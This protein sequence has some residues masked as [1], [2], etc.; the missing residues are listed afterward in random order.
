[1]SSLPPYEQETSLKKK[2]PSKKEK[3]MSSSSTTLAAKNKKESVVAS[4]EAS[5]GP[6]DSS[7]SGISKA[8]SSLN[9]NK[10]ATVAAAAAATAS[11]ASTASSNAASMA[12]A[13]EK[14]KWS[15]VISD[16]DLGDLDEEE[17]LELEMTSSSR[18]SSIRSSRYACYVLGTPALQVSR[19][20]AGLAQL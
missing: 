3:S 16:D 17:G 19:R 8:E 15:E 7:L 1:M 18:S 5:P 12:A 11:T 6:A 14:R 2:S 4:T 20:F 9:N 10:I 13:A